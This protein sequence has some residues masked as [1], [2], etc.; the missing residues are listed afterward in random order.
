[1]AQA[2]PRRDRHL[3]DPSRPRP[4][5]TQADI[6]RLERVQRWVL[7]V[8]AATTIVHLSVGLV[9]GAMFIDEDEVVARVGLCVLGGAFGVIALAAA[10]AIHRR[11]LTD[12]WLLL[13]LLPGVV[14][15]V[16]VLR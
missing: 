11:R 9:I 5:P 8:L 14:G 7:S 15:L 2:P 16:L 3:I 4:R 10:F 13:G 12:P 1:M 6:A